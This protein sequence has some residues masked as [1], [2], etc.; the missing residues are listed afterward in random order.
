METISCPICNSSNFNNHLFLSDRYDLKE[1]TQFSLVK[2]ICNFIFLNPRPN[3]NEILNYYNDISYA[4]HNKF[5]FFYKLAQKISFKW[6]YDL[7]KD[8]FSGHKILDY[9]SGKGDFGNY[10]N[11]RG[12][13]VTSY[14]PISSNVDILNL[15][16]DLITMW[17]SLEHIHDLDETLTKLNE[18]LSPNGHLLIAIPNISAA[19]KKYFST[20]WVAYDAPRHL[21]HFEQNS[22]KNL[23]SKY[24]FKI[25]QIK[26]IYQD[27][28]FNIYKSLNMFKMIF[29]PILFF[30]SII[31]ILINKSKSSS[32]L[33]IC[34]K[35]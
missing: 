25:N 27:T 16:F 32:Q 33:F 3:K 31:E 7:I 14:D 8:N 5:S 35:I 19:E 20:K 2:C 18:K 13:E 10:M 22:L 15:K 21:Y 17:H 30:I 23:I 9:G 4:P 26:P 11:A 34:S 28:F 1:K 12:Y 24:G 29:F 6:K